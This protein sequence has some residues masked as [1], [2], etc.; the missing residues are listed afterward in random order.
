MVK[1]T[2]GQEEL[3]L[4]TIIHTFNITIK[5]LKNVICEIE[6]FVEPRLCKL[7]VGYFDCA[8]YWSSV[9]SSKDVSPY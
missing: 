6:D 1:E 3:L 9:T 8:Y 5:L 2:A 7:R 4:T